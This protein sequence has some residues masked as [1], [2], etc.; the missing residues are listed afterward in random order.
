MRFSQRKGYQPVSQIIQVDSMSSDLRNSIWN[1]LDA[2]IWDQYRF[3]DRVVTSSQKILMRSIFQ[4][5]F[6][7]R[8]DIAAAKPSV[9][10]SGLSK[11]F[12]E[13]DWYQV[14]DFL[15]FVIK[16][17]EYSHLSETINLVLERELA[18]YRIIDG[19]V[20]DVT[21]PQEIES[22]EK[23]LND[24]NFPGVQAHLRT[25]LELMSN[26]EN[27]DY[28]NSI[29]ESISAVES[30]AKTISGKPKATLGD[31]LKVIEKSGQLHPSLREAFSKLYGY[32]NDADGIR[33]AMLDEPNLTAADA[34][35]FLLSC[36]SFINY[37]KSKI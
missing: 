30:L 5:Y 26:K 31:G 7:G 25:A 17:L 13:C 23:T 16:D 28:R 14:Y 32:T 10:F 4:N 34:K 36:A 2:N 27:P 22:L 15:E 24:S 1:V 35:Y 11:Y 37:L 29:K 21:D 8:A 6:K 20:C 33:H 18:G 9:A 19:I 3:H 12:F